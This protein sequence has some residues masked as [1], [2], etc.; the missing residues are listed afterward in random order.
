M[1]TLRGQCFQAFSYL[2]RVAEY[3]ELVQRTM[4]ITC[5]QS[6]MRMVFCTAPVTHDVPLAARCDLSQH[7][8]PYP[9]IDQ[10]G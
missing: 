9:V 10:P 2:L 5:R 7:L 8:L 6:V 4:L 1:L 3:I